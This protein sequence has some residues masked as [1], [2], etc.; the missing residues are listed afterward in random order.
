[1]A[2]WI[3]I[4]LFRSLLHEVIEETL[5][6]TDR[7]VTIYIRPRQHG[8]VLCIEISNIEF[9]VRRELAAYF[10][11]RSRTIEKL[12]ALNVRI[13]N[14]DNGLSISLPLGANVESRFPPP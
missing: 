6:S 9:S 3:T 8:R 12:A 2:S 11:N 1:V 10:N 13:E 14:K 7:T 4:Q 5:R